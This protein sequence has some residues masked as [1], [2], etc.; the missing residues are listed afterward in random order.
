M[1]AGRTRR[2]LSFVDRRCVIG[3]FSFI[4]LL[5][6]LGWGTLIGIVAP[7]QYSLGEAGVLGVALG[8]LAYALGMRHAFDADHIAAIDNTTRKLMAEDQHPRD[9][10]GGQTL[11]ASGIARPLPG[12]TKHGGNA[13]P[14]AGEDRKA[15]VKRDARGGK[16]SHILVGL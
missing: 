2:R 4:A 8:L 14:P 11:R 9:A 3:M 7:A 6:L 10:R 15:G 13:F 16:L 5:H 12:R 1:S